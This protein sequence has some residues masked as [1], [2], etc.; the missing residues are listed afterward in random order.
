MAT[1][2][3]EQPAP[4]APLHVAIVMDGNGRWAKRRG[5]PRQVGH[6]KGVD[7]IRRVVEAAPNQGIR[8]LTLYAF[9]TENWRRPAGEVA[10]VMRLLK[11]YVNSDLDKLV[12]EG[13][14]VRILGRREGLPPDV[15]EIVERAERQTAHNDKFFLQ[16]AFNYG[17][18]ADLVDAAR[19]LATDVAEGRITADDITDEL[20]EAKLSTGG[21]PAPDLVIRTS[22]EQRL[23]NFLLWE[24]AY[25]EFVFQD[26]LWPDFTPRHLAEGIAEYQ[27]RERRYGGAVADNVLAAG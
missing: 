26:V 7:A 19:A 11:L 21:L 5:L 24:S 18:R 8:W 25:S 12:R 6:P 9:S 14:K 22:G 16:V 27:K 4:H 23:S 10:E 13:V 2:D 3:Q 17:G 15:A 1:V 20:L